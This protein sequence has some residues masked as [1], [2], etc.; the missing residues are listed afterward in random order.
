MRFADDVVQLYLQHFNE[1][2]F[3]SFELFVQSIL[4][5][6]DHNDLLEVFQRC[7]KEELNRILT[8]Y[9]SEDIEDKIKNSTTVEDRDERTT[10]KKVQ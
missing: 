8:N 4:E 5:Q 2:E 9:L 1:N 3:D 6:M 7:D 10:C